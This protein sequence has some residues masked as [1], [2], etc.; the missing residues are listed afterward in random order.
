MTAVVTRPAAVE[1]T[2]Q[3]DQPDSFDAAAGLDLAA[4]IALLGYSVAVAVG[5]SRVFIGD[6][7][8]RDLVLI[9]TIG[10]GTSYLLRLVRAPSFVAIPLVLATLTWAVAW[11][12]Y[13]HTFSGPFPLSDTW[14]MVRADFRVIENDFQTATAPVPYTAGWAFVAGATMG[15]VV[16]LADTFAFRAQARGEA[17]V[18][19]AVLFVFIAALGV[20]ENRVACSLLVIGAGFVALAVLRLRASRPA[21]SILGPDRHPLARLVV[22]LI[23]AT[24]LVL[25]GAWAIAPHLPGADAE[26]W[27][28]THNDRGGVTEIISPLVDI[29]QRLVNQADTELFTVQADAPSYWR[30]S[31][32]PRFDGNSWDLPESV[33]G[34]TDGALEQ[35]I[36]GS[37]ENHQIVTIDGLRGALVPAAPNPVSAR[38]LDGYNALSASLVKTDSPLRGRRRV[39]HRVGDAALQRRR[40]AGRVVELAAGLD[41]P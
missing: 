25:A 29:R 39:R 34:D 41:V 22:P 6:A 2:E 32:L 35:G 13:P 31:A 10:H 23:G 1:G 26:P 4:T 9:A 17:L 36:P 7:Y 37:V 30:A 20:D 3:D 8:L 16:W 18:P 19:G 11:I 21:R 33:L 14:N 24:A 40:P 15:A 5:F 28:D 38:G 27:F 12:Y